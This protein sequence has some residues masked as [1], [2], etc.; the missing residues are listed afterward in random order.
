MP[1]P[2]ISVHPDSPHVFSAGGRNGDY[3]FV[4]YGYDPRE[5]RDQAGAVLAEQFPLAGVDFTA[6]EV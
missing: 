1:S 3:G 4:R 6:H 5:S 2:R